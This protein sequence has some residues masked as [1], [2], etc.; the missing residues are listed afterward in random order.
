MAEAASAGAA[1]LAAA[2]SDPEPSRSTAVNLAMAASDFTAV[3]LA[4]AASG[5][6][7]NLVAVASGSA[8][9]GSK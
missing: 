1:L 3:N 9:V 6:D 5:S 8:A 2:T 4:T 7:A